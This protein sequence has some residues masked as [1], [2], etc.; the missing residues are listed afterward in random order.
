MSTRRSV[1]SR[2]SGTRPNCGGLKILA[3]SRDGFLKLG[4]EK[5]ARKTQALID[6][7][8]RPLS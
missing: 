3:R 6:Q 8:A 1:S 5:M 7:L 4:R 2:S